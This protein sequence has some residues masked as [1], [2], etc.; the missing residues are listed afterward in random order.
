MLRQIGIRLTRVIPVAL[1]IT[2]LATAAVDLMPGSPAL[3]MLG[4]D[5]TPQQVTAL[6]HQMGLDQPFVVRYLGWLGGALHGD[7]GTSLRL[8]LPVSQVLWQRIPVTAEVGILAMLIALVLAVPLAM[9][10]ASSVGGSFDRITSGAS[11]GV[12]AMP[13][14]AAAVLLILVFA[15]E[16]R[17]FPVSGWVPLTVDPLENLRH[18]FLP[19]LVLGL[20]EAAVFYRLLRNDVIATLRETF[21]LAARARGMEKVYILFRHALRPSLF[22]LITVMGLSLGRL[23][24]GAMVVEV[25]FSLPGLGALMLQSVPSRD[26]PVIQ[27]IVLV[28]ALIYVIANIVVDLTYAAIDPRIRTAKAVA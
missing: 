22:S 13:S 7:L 15:I 14:F 18:A 26:I 23:L 2:L 8:D 17:W 11:A 27:G 20:A 3:A 4:N 5:A 28:M 24:G 16:L 12:L 6:E 9:R 1:I 25:L 19:A 21:V 10:S